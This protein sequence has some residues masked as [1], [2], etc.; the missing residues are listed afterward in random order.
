MLHAIKVCIIV[1]MNR[2]AW[3]H[4]SLHCLT[5]CNIIFSHVFFIIPTTS[6]IDTTTLISDK[7]VVGSPRSPFE[8]D[9]TGLSDCPFWGINLA[10]NSNYPWLCSPNQGPTPHGPASFERHGREGHWCEAQTDLDEASS[11]GTQPHISS[12]TFDDSPQQT[13]PWRHN[14]EHDKSWTQL[15]A[16]WKDKSSCQLCLYMLFEWKRHIHRKWKQRKNKDCQGRFR[17]FLN[18]QLTENP[19]KRCL[20]FGFDPSIL[21]AA[22]WQ[23]TSAVRKTVA[24]KWKVF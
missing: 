12:V 13:E 24:W 5:S 7:L 19:S 2:L 16:E 4:Q 3:T 6:N 20:R 23:S 8:R 17:R 9:H 14:T 15:N 11:W 1:H 10:L 21:G 18:F 22:K